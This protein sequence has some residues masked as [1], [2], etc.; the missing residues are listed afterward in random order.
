MNLQ[1]ADQPLIALKV[2]HV[3]DI[4]QIGVLLHNL[5][6]IMPAFDK[7]EGIGP[8]HSVQFLINSGVDLL[9]KV[10]LKQLSEEVDHGLKEV[11]VLEDVL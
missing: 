5:I 2:R 3:L 6:L 7:V 11:L 10:L 8:E 4:L 9:L 1:P